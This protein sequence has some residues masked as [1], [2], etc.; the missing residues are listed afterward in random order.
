[1]IT[2]E[3]KEYFPGIAAIEKASKNMS[4]REFA[5]YLNQNNLSSN[6]QKMGL[7]GELSADIDPELNEFLKDTLAATTRIQRQEE[8]FLDKASKFFSRFNFKKKKVNFEKEDLDKLKEDIKVHND[9]SQAVLDKED[10]YHDP[11]E[12]KK[13]QIL[14]KKIQKADDILKSRP[15]NQGLGKAVLEQ[16]EKEKK[17]NSTENRLANKIRNHH[18]KSKTVTASKS[19]PSAGKQR[20]KSAAEVRGL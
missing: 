4:A 14:E 19:T 8:T 12:Y 11:V 9:A 20:R 7:N 1:M 6:I 16:M 15:K 13:K 5:N 10:L 2:E 17:L 3:Y 18:E